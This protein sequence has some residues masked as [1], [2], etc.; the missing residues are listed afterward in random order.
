MS[1]KAFNWKMAVAA[2]GEEYLKDLAK[3]LPDGT[4]DASGMM[5]ADSA[6]NADDDSGPS[7]YEF[8]GDWFQYTYFLRCHET[9]A[10]T[11]GVKND[12]IIPVCQCP[13]CTNDLWKTCKAISI[14]CEHNGLIKV[15]L[16]NAMLFSAH[17]ENAHLWNAHLEN[18]N[19]ERAHLENAHLENAHLERA[20]LENAKLYK[21]NLD[22]ADVHGATGLVFDHNQVDRLLIRG[23]APDPWSVLRREYTGPWFFFHLI[24][25]ILFLLPYVGKTLF[26]T[27]ES[28]AVERIETLAENSVENIPESISP[29]KDYFQQQLDRWNKIPKVS[30]FWPLLGCPSGWAISLTIFL[31]I[32]N[33]LRFILTTHVSLLRDAEERSKITPDKKEYLGESEIQYTVMFQKNYWIGRWKAI[34]TWPGK[35]RQQCPHS[36]KSELPKFWASVGLYRVHLLMSK[37]MWIGYGIVVWQV[38]KWLWCV[39][40]PMR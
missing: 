5:P 30:A 28:K 22:K 25:L 7:N 24:L 26:F 14:A 6:V 20:H 3:H 38:A 9:P 12:G 21:A 1:Q 19:L 10:E 13:F 8:R 40:I 11:R 33:G 39:Q 29:V 34:K 2:F 32:Y 35:M 16:E 4:Q 17:L 23:D 27:W 15:H 31:I 37:M 18:A 36:S